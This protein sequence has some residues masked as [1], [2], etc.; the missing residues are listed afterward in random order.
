MNECPA[1]SSKKSKKH[2]KHPFQVRVCS[3]CGAIF[4]PP[5]SA[6]YLGESY[7]IVL[8]RFTTDPSADERAVYFDLDTL[9]SEGLGRR[10]GWFDPATG[11]LTQVG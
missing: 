8:P 1:C 10:H 9:G 6:I 11:L 7:E 3:R 2:P 5:G 4:T